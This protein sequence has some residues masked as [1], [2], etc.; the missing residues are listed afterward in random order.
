MQQALARKALS[1]PNNRFQ[2]LY[3][4]VR[5]EVWLRTALESVLGNKGARTPGIDGITKEKLESE[6]AR[7]KL[8][9]KVAGELQDGRYAPEPVV[10]T[11][12]PKANGKLRPLG[13]PTLT[14]RMV[15]ECLRMV[16]EPIY[17][18][19]FLPFSYG[20][21][22]GRRTMDAIVRIQHLANESVR[23]F[24]VV[25]GDITGCFDN[26]PHDK[27]LENLAQT[28]DDRRLLRLVRGMLAA[29]YVEEGRLYTPNRG[30][31]QGGVVSPLLANIYLHEMDVIWDRKY[32]DLTQYRR[33]QIRKAGGGNVKL[34]RYADD[35]LLMTNGKKQQAQEIKDEAALILDHLGLQLSVEKTLVTHVNDGFTFLGFHLQR[36]R[37]PQDPTRYGMIVTPTERN[38]KRFQD[39]IEK[40]LEDL[41]ADVRN[42]IK[43]LNPVLRGWASYYRHVASYD[44]RHKLDTWM[45]HRFL[46]W[47]RW[48]HGNTIG[49]QALYAMYNTR[50][51]KGWLNWGYGGEHLVVMQRDIRWERYLER[52]IPHPYLDSQGSLI[53]QDEQ[54][55]EPG[56]TWD[57]TSSQNH[58]AIARLRRMRE[59]NFTCENCHRGPLPIAALHAH[60]PQGKS[61][62]QFWRV[63]T[64]LCEDC[65][66]KTPSYGV[67]TDLPEY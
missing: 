36:E 32:T 49:K 51:Q 23:Y 48:K 4:L 35:F 45:W 40:I 37:L 38:V 50:D 26:I 65:H 58:Y 21:R 52:K 57:G 55:I 34:V 12:I 28:I 14:D 29:G 24:W 42:K 64:I 59:V 46:I 56:V 61:D 10:R 22:P 31:P 33:Y 25:E 3:G 67:N 27:L 13:I 63:I 30:T 6:E 15:Q 60:H 53:L 43:A 17:E 19:R 7:G 9:K 11:Y 20:F 39:K 41:S 16:F 62:P 47:L 54:P 8:V 18:S 1:Q 66:K 5:N 2:D 44:V